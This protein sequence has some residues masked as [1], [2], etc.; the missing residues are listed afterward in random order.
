[1]EPSSILDQIDRLKAQLPA[2][3]DRAT[4]REMQRTIRFLLKQYREAMRHRPAWHG[5]KS[6]VAWLIFAF[7]AIVT[8][9]TAIERIYGWQDAAT[10][11]TV[12]II[13][14]ILVTAMFF[15]MVRSI[16]QETYASLVKASLRRIPWPGAVRREL[17]RKEEIT[18]SPPE[19]SSRILSGDPLNSTND[20]Y[21][22]PR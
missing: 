5:M 22:G 18:A 11:F 19:A 4:R 21:L 14:L 10:S 8:V 16:S 15:L 1:M 2:E 3:T 13:L 6:N 12:G 17:P 7:F 20:E 9:C